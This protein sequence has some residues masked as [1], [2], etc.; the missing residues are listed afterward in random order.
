MIF[1]LGIMP[2]IRTQWFGQENAALR[3][4]NIELRCNIVEINKLLQNGEF[5]DA[6]KLSQK[7]VTQ[8]TQ[9]GLLITE[10]EEF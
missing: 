5:H 7:I 8:I 9:P 4:E 10:M 3:R 2:K 1:L 6:K